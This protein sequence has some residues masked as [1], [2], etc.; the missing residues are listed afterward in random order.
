MK[1]APANPIISQALRSAGAELVGTFFLA[2]A[3]LTAPS[4]LKP[5]AVGLTLLVFVYA[6]GG[7]SG[8]HLNP[9]VAVVIGASKATAVT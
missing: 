5:F 4:P 3:A 1:D 8:S 2:P 9:A 6:V 7:L